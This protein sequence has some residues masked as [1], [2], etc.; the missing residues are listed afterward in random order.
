MQ[1]RQQI[2]ERT[3]FQ[4]QKSLTCKHLQNRKEKRDFRLSKHGSKI[5]LVL[6]GGLEPPQAFRSL[7]PETSVSTNFTTPALSMMRQKLW[8]WFFVKVIVMLR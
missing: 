7:V 4:Y 6:K 2:C 3:R 8:G 5:E 1:S